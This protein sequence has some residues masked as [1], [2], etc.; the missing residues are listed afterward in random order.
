MSQ[1]NDLLETLERSNQA[2][3]WISEQAFNNK[4]FKQFNIH[5]IVYLSAKDKFN[6]SAQMVI[7]AISKVADS[8]QIQKSKQ[9]EFRKHGSVAYDSRLLTFK[10]GDKVS[11]W[12]LKG[13]QTIAFVCGE[14]QRKLLPF[15]K[16]EVDL[17]YRKGQFFL[18]AVCDVPEESPL[19][20]N[21][22]LGVD[23]GI[24]LLATDSTGESFSG[25]DVES[26]RLK[27][28]NQRQLL[29]HKASKQSQSGKRPRKI[30]ELIKR[31]SG[32]EKN[33]RKHENH[34]ISKKLVEKAKALN[35][36]IAV[37]DLKHIR[38]RIEKTVRPNQRRKISGWSFFELRSFVEYKST[39]NGLPVYSV[40]PRNTSRTCHRCG[41]CEKA[42]RLS[43]S[44]FICKNCDLHINADFNAALNIRDRGL[45]NVLQSSESIVLKN[46]V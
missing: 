6:L 3:N 13:R 28:S 16:G 15:L 27:Y 41:H 8:Y 2:C 44:E 32:R 11:L 22:V 33:F 1:H 12:T 5:K 20:P 14:R 30:H 39:L 36:G 9:P 37:E 35:F 25:K 10:C 34:V 38:K 4:V 24:V 23:F 31:L 7:R 17:I 19:I 42:N 43:Q 40:D 29:Q 26:I 45:V 18:N 46:A 21:D